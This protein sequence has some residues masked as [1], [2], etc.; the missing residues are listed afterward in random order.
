MFGA[1]GMEVM[2]GLIAGKG[3]ETIVGETSNPWVRRK[4]D[5]IR[6]ALTGAIGATQAFTVK[7]CLD[8][9]KVI[10]AKILE[11]DAEIKERVV[12][13]GREEDLKIAMSVPGVGFI[14][15]ST[16][17]AEIGDV[18]DF[19]TADQLASWT[20]IVPSVYQSADKLSLG[21]ITKHGSKHLRWILVEVAHATLRV[22]RETKLNQFFR[23]VKARQGTKKAIV[24]L[25]RKILT[26]LHHLLTKREPYTED[27]EPVKRTKNT[28]M[29]N[30][31]P[32]EMTT[33]EMIRVLSEA[34]YVIRKPTT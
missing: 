23:R 1:S 31:A 26:I 30:R 22:K 15:A 24:A 28:N 33:D 27:G 9:I 7:A 32:A 3:V 17:L 8:V 16:M 13:C 2:K 20:G 25:A 19:K 34:G 4:A 29:R 21:R 6:K 14:S 5:E 12:R 11:L 18:R 10:D